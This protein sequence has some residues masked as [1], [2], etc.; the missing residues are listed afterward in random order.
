MV[1]NQGA[2]KKSENNEKVLKPVQ[3]LLGESLSCIVLLLCSPECVSMLLMDRSMLVGWSVPIQNGGPRRSSF[4]HDGW[5]WLGTVGGAMTLLIACMFHG[6]MLWIEAT[7]SLSP[8]TYSVLSRL[9][10]FP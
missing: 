10:R 5:V 9:P 7:A 4:P 2:Q 8:E 3:E 6:V 1:W